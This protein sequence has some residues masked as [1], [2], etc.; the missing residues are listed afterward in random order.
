MPKIL[1]VLKKV[2]T[3]GTYYFVVDD[4]GIENP[5]TDIMGE[6][7]SPTEYGF[8]IYG[9]GGGCTAWRKEFELG[10][11]TPAY[12]LVTQD[13]SH[14][15]DYTR[16]VE[17]GVYTDPEHAIDEGWIA[18]EIDTENNVTGLTTDNWRD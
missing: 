17:L 10:D 6:P 5:T 3:K 12:M 8:Y 11:G 7:C 9:T 16:P 18:W 13:M 4:M 2:Q 1:Q 15:I 14:E